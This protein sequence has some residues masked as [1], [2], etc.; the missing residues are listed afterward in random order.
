VL[1]RRRAGRHHHD[2]LPGHHD[3]DRTGRHHEHDDGV[4]V[5]HRV[6]PDRMQGHR[7]QR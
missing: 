4:D 2:H 5:E 6:G 7:A 3:H 1:L